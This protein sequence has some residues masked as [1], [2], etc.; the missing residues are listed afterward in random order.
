[1]CAA[2]VKK[3]TLS[4][5]IL[6]ETTSPR[7]AW[8]GFEVEGGRGSGVSKALYEVRLMATSDMSGSK[9][10]RPATNATAGAAAAPSKSAAKP[11]SDRPSAVTKGAKPKDAKAH[12]A[13]GSS[14]PEKTIPSQPPAHDPARFGRG[15][16]EDE[17]RESGFFDND[18]LSAMLDTDYERTIDQIRKR[19]RRFERYTAI[20]LVLFSLGVLTSG[21]LTRGAVF[22]STLELLSNLENPDSRPPKDPG[23]NCQN[24]K[25]RNTPYCQ[26][27]FGDVDSSWR[28][29]GRFQ[30]GTAPA[31]SLS[32]PSRRARQ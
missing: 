15:D 17:I 9:T 30:G 5:D 1:M 3:M 14:A 26:E 27:R 2:A 31:F 25:N 6:R 20:F 24:P 28:S 12:A 19:E 32:A 16:E 11:A 13:G 22:T 4:A 10:S 18:A 7:S 8:S 21:L 23:L 29:V